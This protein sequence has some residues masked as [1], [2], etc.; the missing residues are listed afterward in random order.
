MLNCIL[1]VQESFISNLRGG[2][3]FNCILNEKRKEKN[4][5]E[6]L[7]T[8]Q[9]VYVRYVDRRLSVVSIIIS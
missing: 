2:I 8:Y 1:I 7:Q 6:L 4:W 5:Y 9:I 3:K